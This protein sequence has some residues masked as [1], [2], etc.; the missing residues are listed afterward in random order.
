[1]AAGDGN[2]LQLRARGLTGIVC[3]SKSIVVYEPN[4]L[5]LI[6]PELDVWRPGEHNGTF[7]GQPGFVTAAAALS[8]GGRIAGARLERKSR[9]VES[10]LNEM[11]RKH[12]GC[13][14]RRGPD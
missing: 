7:R 5:V 6:K 12:P 9:L 10:R 11:L 13:G 1:M 14:Q 8:T 4:G 2:V 3:L